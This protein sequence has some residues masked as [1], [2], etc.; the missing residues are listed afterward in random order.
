[1]IEVSIWYPVAR[2]IGRDGLTED[3]ISGNVRIEFVFPKR[4]FLVWWTQHVGAEIP[5]PRGYG[6]AHRCWDRQE[7]LLA[8]MPFNI[9]IGGVIW[10]WQWLR[11]GFAEW[12][13]GHRPRKRVT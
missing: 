4:P 6:V 3:A 9:L 2:V 5:Y 10:V 13:W 1:M 7:L 11:V 12:C 8:P